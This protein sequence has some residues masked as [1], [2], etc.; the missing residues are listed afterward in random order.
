MS[1]KTCPICN[2]KVRAGRFEKHLRKAHKAKMCVC[3]GDAIEIQSYD[4][5]LESCNPDIASLRKTILESGGKVIGK[6]RIARKNERVARY[7]MSP[8]DSLP[9]KTDYD[10][11]KRDYQTVSGGAYGLGKNRKH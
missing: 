11:I 2:A 5:H 10:E 9:Q 7:K 6:K 3:C 8:D 1:Q 4:A